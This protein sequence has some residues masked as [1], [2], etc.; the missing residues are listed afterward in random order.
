MGNVVNQL[1][2]YAKGYLIFG[3]VIIVT[4]L[5]FFIAIF[6]YVLRFIIK[7]DKEFEK[8]FNRHKKFRS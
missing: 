6:I 4:Y 2:P 7:K 8:K 5:I 3:A 1:L